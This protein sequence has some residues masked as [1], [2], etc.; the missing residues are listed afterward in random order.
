MDVFVPFDA[1]SPKSRLSS[2]FDL[3]ERRAFARIMMRD[4]LD[5]VDAAGLDPVVLATAD[6][7]VGYPVRVDDRALS[8]AVNA[9]IDDAAGP[10]AVVVAD[11]PLA[12]P[13]ALERLV[14][15]DAAVVLAPGLGGGTNAMVVREPGFRADYHGASIRDHR[16]RAR[17]IGVEPAVVDSFRLAVDVD[18]PGDLAEVLLHGEGR[19]VEWLRDAGVELV[20]TD[21]RVGVERSC[22]TS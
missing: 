18:E 1:D 17:A 4:V 14:E 2:I 7:D 5:A 20:V 21:G 15:R 22:Q 3:D 13:A 8:T 10:L 6:V 9:A 16:G 11:L 12:S 19:A